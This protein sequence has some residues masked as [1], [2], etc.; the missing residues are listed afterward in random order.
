[1]ALHKNRVEKFTDYS[2]SA[3]KLESVVAAVAGNIK[4]KQSRER[5]PVEKK[6][7]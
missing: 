2:N 4:V 3:N 5:K 7:S 6:A 1:M